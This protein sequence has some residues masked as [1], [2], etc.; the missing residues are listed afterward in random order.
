M[1]AALNQLLDDA[2]DRL[3][4][5]DFMSP[6]LL[7]ASIESIGS[8]ILDDAESQRCPEEVKE[9][10][11]LHD[12]IGDFLRESSTNAFPRTSSFKAFPGVQDI[13]GK[14]SN[15]LLGSVDDKSAY[16]PNANQ[17]NGAIQECSG[18]ICHLILVSGTKVSDKEHF[19]QFM[20]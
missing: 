9:T 13:I 8:W 3:E 14:F 19:D 12:D 16:S 15:I 20:S 10:S 18:V 5:F 2:T 6:N 4:P 11:Y 17:S 1:L 7:R